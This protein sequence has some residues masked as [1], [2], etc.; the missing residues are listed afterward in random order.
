MATPKAAVRNKLRKLADTIEELR[1][2]KDLYWGLNVTRL[3]S[4]KSLCENHAVA[5]QFVL[6]LARRT[7]ENMEEKPCSPYK[8]PDDWNRIK[9]FAF[10]AFQRLQHCF[11]LPEH[12]QEAAFH[13][14]FL[15]VRNF[16]NTHQSGKHGLVRIIQSQ[17][18][19]LLEYALECIMS[20][21]QYGRWAYQVARQYVEGSSYENGLLP[22]SIPMLEE[23]LDFWHRHYYHTPEAA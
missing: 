15:E 19:L 16:Q 14:L 7:I 21:Q 2:A 9:A 20:S 17:D 1:E 5:I 23:I 12:E 13:E 22:E 6:F 18:I 3:T 11:E 4:I 8:D 10:S